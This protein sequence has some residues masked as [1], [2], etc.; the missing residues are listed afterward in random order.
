MKLM[1]IY[2][3][4]DAIGWM[5]QINITDNEFI[6]LDDN[7]KSIYKVNFHIYEYL[8]EVANN[9]FLLYPKNCKCAFLFSPWLTN[10]LTCWEWLKVALSGLLLLAKCCYVISSY[11]NC[12]CYCYCYY[13]P[14]AVSN[15]RSYCAKRVGST[16]WSMLNQYY[17]RANFDLFAALTDRVSCFV[18]S[19][20]SKEKWCQ[21]NIPFGTV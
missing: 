17:Q 15:T 18:I 8:S 19:L 14:N 10:R 4:F 16:I 9:K 12:F 20:W 1:K 11:W 13:W 3:K 7:G 5:K 6:Y 21:K 2:I